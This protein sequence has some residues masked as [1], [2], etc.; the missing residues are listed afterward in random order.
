LPRFSPLS[1]PNLDVLVVVGHGRGGRS[2]GRRCSPNQLDFESADIVLDE[3]AGERGPRGRAP[4]VTAGAATVRAA[5]RR[6]VL[7]GSAM[8][9]KSTRL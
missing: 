8:F 6:P 7:D 5:V 3:A 2:T 1:L 9:A 4:R